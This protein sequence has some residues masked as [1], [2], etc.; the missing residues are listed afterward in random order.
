M[1]Q[2]PDRA[3]GSWLWMPIT[4]D[5]I[6]HFDQMK[7]FYRGLAAGEAYP[8]WE[9]DTNRG[10]GAPTTSYYPP[11]AYYLTSALYAIVRDWMWT[12]LLAQILMMA[13]S[14][15]AIYLYARR[16]LSLRAA[17][18]AMTAYIFLPYHTVDQYQRGALAELLGFAF[19]PLMLLFAENL[20][21]DTTQSAKA[22][23]RRP[24]EGE[25]DYDSFPK[26][27]AGS[28]LL[29]NTAGLAATLGAFLWCHPPTAY[30]F[31]IA[32]ALFVTAS[33][34]MHKSWKGLAPMA[35]AIALGSGL[36]AAYIYPAFVEQNLIR[37]EFISSTWPYSGTY[38]FAHGSGY[39]FTDFI[40][41]FN[42]VAIALG[43]VTLL[44]VERRLVAPS[45]GLRQ[46]VWLWVMIG[47]VSSFLM[48]K[49]SSP[50]GSLIPKLDIGVFAWRMLAITTL[51]AALIAGACAQAAFNG[52]RLPRASGS[53]SL[54]S[55]TS[56][57]IL[58]GAVF[59]TARIM[60]PIWGAPPFEAAKE[61][62]NVAMMPVTAPVEPLELPT[63]ERAELASGQDHVEVEDW[64]PERRVLR[65]ESSSAD[66]LLIRTFN[67]PG[68]SATVDGE[69][70]SIVS[71]DALRVEFDASEQALIR[72]DTFR[73][74]TPIVDGKPGRIVGRESLGDIVIELRPGPHRVTLAYLDTAPRRLGAVI[75]ACAA[76]FVVGLIAAALVMRSR[77]SQAMNGL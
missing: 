33:T 8:R 32:F 27:K 60:L 62:V 21:A 35:I 54:A 16:F 47:C 69:P 36:A 64:R 52:V 53:N 31:A 29:L 48:L 28:R 12:I 37:H 74:V 50:L 75:T 9:E 70:A 24:L 46:R 3:D 2:P 77:A 68:W 41:I 26:V 38:I 30:Q 6:L 55:M 66:K 57:A 71:G 65:V 58:G 59:V 40:W 67:F 49:S 1:S 63:V 7:S 22:S 23:G 4:H 17:I 34:L 42:A 45:S 25:E 72:A 20:L 18:V 73:G 13:A 5:M 44:W 19:M 11:G 43:A 39:D 61:H 56:V 76:L 10:F 15:F 51:V 14:G